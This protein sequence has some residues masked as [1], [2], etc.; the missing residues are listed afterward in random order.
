MGADANPEKTASVVQADAGSAAMAVTVWARR[1][2]L[3]ASLPIAA[4]RPA[5]DRCCVVPEVGI[6]FIL[7]LVTT[8]LV[9]INSKPMI[10]IRSNI[11]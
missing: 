8:V 11:S 9:G 7:Y 4:V 5:G 2:V 10:S 3:K 6:R 1:F